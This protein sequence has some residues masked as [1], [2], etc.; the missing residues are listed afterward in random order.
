[1]KKRAWTGF[2]ICAIFIIILM[3]LVFVSPYVATWDEVDYVLGLFEYDL[4]KMQPHFPGYPLFILT[5][6]IIHQLFSSGDQSLAL[7][8][9]IVYASAS[10][11]IYYLSRYFLDK[12]SSILVV[13]LIQTVPY[14]SLI[15]SLPMSEGMAL[16][17]MW[18]YIWAIFRFVNEQKGIE[19]PFLLFAVL[20][21]VRLSYLPLGTGLVYLAY[22]EW[23]AK[24][25]LTP[26]VYGMSVGVIGIGIW[27]SALAANSGGIVS[28]YRLATGFTEG[29][30]TEWGGAV[31]ES[32]LGLA[33]LSTYMINIFWI[34][35]SS[36]NLLL[37]MVFS[38]L[39][40][41]TINHL[42]NGKKDGFLPL[43]SLLFISYFIWA[44]FAQNIEKAR[45]ILP[46]V[47]LFSMFC[48]IIMLK[49]GRRLGRVLVITMVSAQFFVTC[50]L[51]WQAH[52]ELPAVYQVKEFV[53]SEYVQ[54]TV[55]TWEETRVFGYLEADFTHKR[56]Y[57][58]EQF[59][60]DARNEKGPILLTN[61]V[62]EGFIEQGVDITEHITEVKRFDSMSLRDPIYSTIV[63]Y[64]W[65]NGG[66]GIER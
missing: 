16:G 62:I 49:E 47:G 57:T 19:W 58:Y 43:L 32:T 51:L 64:E 41:Y 14:A 29:H 26:L 40:L 8:N 35:I 37:F 30:F 36:E 12:S 50:Q 2:M 34:G 3:K 66:E 65:K 13:L 54:A 17:V 5:G 38:S 61:H 7:A 1:M 18:W 11:P 46:L 60:G 56:M 6:M 4:W 63:L 52:K 31:N 44:F 10:V 25:P 48:S 59:L 22:V 28:L 33:R 9:Q 20:L 27:G 23:K 45:H 15:S 21:G 53:E 42:T 55:Y 39:V 24:R